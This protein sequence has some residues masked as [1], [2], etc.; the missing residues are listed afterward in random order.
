MSDNFNTKNMT[1]TDISAIIFFFVFTLSGF[2][3]NFVR[4]SKPENI[5][6]TD[7]KKSLFWFRILVPA[8]LIASEIFYFLRIGSFSNSNIFVVIGYTLLIGGLAIRWFS[9]LS[10]G[11]EFNVSLSIIKNHN[12]KTN[13]IYKYIRHPSYT[14]LLV[15][16]LGLAILM[17]NIFSIIL[18][19]I[20]PFI[21]V[22]NR[23]RIEENLL[24]MY[25]KNNYKIYSEKTKK[26][27]PF[28]Y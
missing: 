6:F 11:K 9:V 8:G 16:Y 2:I 18:L 13:G 28:I 24:S 17:Q 10:L 27:F 22:F 23:I 20:L 26:L 5:Q 7:D 14:G 12:L 21:A 15:Y 19:T 1:F 25:F 4:G 3:I